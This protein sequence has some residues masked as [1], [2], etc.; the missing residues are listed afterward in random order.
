MQEMNKIKKLILSSTDDIE[1]MFLANKGLD[2]AKEFFSLPIEYVPST[3][4]QLRK[5][6]HCGE[7]KEYDYFRD[8]RY[9]CRACDCERVRR[10]VFRRVH[11]SF[12]N[13]SVQ[14]LA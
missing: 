9:T 3:F 1:K 11:K 4:N 7:L 13:K 6:N 10:S 12:K 5:C 8:G 14:T 2:L